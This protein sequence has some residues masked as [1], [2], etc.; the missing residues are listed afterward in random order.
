MYELVAAGPT[1]GTSRDGL[2]VSVILDWTHFSSVRL[3][4]NCLRA[5]SSTS[6]SFHIDGTMQLHKLGCENTNF[7]HCSG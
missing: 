4:T 5:Q 6:K 2:L 1:A 3:Q 7:E